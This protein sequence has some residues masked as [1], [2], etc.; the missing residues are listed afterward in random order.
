M[1][2]VPN[3]FR[4]RR[5][6]WARVFAL[7]V[8]GTS[9]ISRP[10]RCGARSR[11]GF[12]SVFARALPGVSGGLI[13]ELS[14]LYW[15]RAPLARRGITVPPVDERPASDSRWPGLRFGASGRK[16]GV[17]RVS[18]TRLARRF[19]SRTPSGALSPSW[20]PG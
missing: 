2:K 14:T 5:A 17:P 19:Q 4:C 20:A 1:A 18:G 15:L 11:A 3:I 9:T 13:F 6:S 16:A 7:D 12:R 10:P 8:R